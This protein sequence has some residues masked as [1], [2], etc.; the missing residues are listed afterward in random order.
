MLGLA[1]L[2]FLVM[3]A[4]Q[5]P[6]GTYTTET[7]FYHYYAPDA[8]RL[9]SG[10]FPA[11]TFQGPGYPAVIA[12]VAKLTGH[13]DDLF[14]VGKWLSVLCAIACGWLIYRLFAQVFNP[15][16]GL[17]AQA[18]AIVSGEFLSFSISATTDVFFLLLCLA[19]LVV[20]TND[21]QHA[22]TRSLWAG[23]LAGA[24]YVTRYNGLFLLATG[25]CGIVLLNLFV[26]SRRERMRY[27]VIFLGLF[28]LIASPWL[29]ANGRHYG[30]PFYNANYLNIATEFFPELVK[31]KTNQDATRAMAERFHSFG[32]VLRYDPARLLKRYPANLWESLRNVVREGLLNRWLAWLALLGAVLVWFDRRART[33]LMLEIG[34]VVYLLLMAL[35]HWE[36]RYYFLVMALCAG[37]AAY[38]V[39][40][41]YEWM[42]Q[43]SFS[44]RAGGKRAAFIALPVMVSVVLWLA[45]FV[46]GNQQLREFLANHP[47]EVPATRSYLQ[48]VGQCPSTQN[49]RIIRIVARKPHVPYLCRGEWVFFPQVESLEELRAWL[50]QNPVDY[51]LISQRELKERKKLKPL[52]DPA[53][54][55]PWLRPVWSSTEPLIVVYQPNAP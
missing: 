50:Q 52:G 3:A 6:F 54:A 24:A 40:R 25:L 43:Q 12:F 49:V 23:A 7:D 21:R 2:S 32:E 31:G 48:S 14:T 30:S 41:G 55:P 51:L 42:Q 39:M 17:A 53:K 44:Q 4:R 19:T 13:S 36:T 15:W 9:A 8:E 34:G 38:A 46:Q 33:A 27:A 11:N 16:V 28:L 22:L 35:N 26:L 47:L 29:I 18:F 20:L 37:L 45:A 1:Q 10:Q 5:H